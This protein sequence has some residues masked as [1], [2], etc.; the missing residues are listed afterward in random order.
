[1]AATKRKHKLKK[2]EPLPRI[3]G[4]FLICGCDLSMYGPAFALMQ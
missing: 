1:M 3:E 4:D 2:K